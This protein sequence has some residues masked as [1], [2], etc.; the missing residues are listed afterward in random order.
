MYAGWELSLNE[1]NCQALLVLFLFRREVSKG[2]HEI[3]WHSQEHPSSSKTR[4]SMLSKLLDRNLPPRCWRTKEETRCDS[5]TPKVI[6]M[7]I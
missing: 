1:E 6:R 5:D 2:L 7:K 3:V 4:V